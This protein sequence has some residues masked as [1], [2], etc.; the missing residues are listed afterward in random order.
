M[1]QQFSGRLAGLLE[2]SN[3]STTHFRGSP[4]EPRCDHL[5]IVPSMPRALSGDEVAPDHW[6]R[7]TSP[8][9][10]GITFTVEGRDEAGT[11][12]GT[13]RRELPAYRSVR[14]KMRDIEAAFDATKPEGWWRL[15]VTGSGTLE[16]TASIRQGDERRFVPVTV[17]AT[18]PAGAVTRR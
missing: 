4:V 14:V 15:V 3:G 2:D 7:I 11:K 6:I 10:E 5:A 18:C 16:V 9:G 13:Y 1:Q 12:A 17:P 8:G